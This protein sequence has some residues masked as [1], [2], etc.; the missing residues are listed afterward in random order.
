MKNIRTEELSFIH[1][2]YALYLH[3]D[4]RILIDITIFNASQFVCYLGSQ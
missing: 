4:A 2:R 1:T 3:T